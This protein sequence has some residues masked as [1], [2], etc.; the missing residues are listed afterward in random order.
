MI[1]KRRTKKCE[2]CDREISL[3]NVSKHERYHIKN[4]NK[5][6]IKESWNDGDGNY[7]CPYCEK[8]YKK[9]G[10]GNH[11]FRSHT[12]RGKNFF[13]NITGKIWN[14]GLTKETDERV[15]KNA[16]SIKQA[17][18]KNGHPSIGKTHS[19]ES[20]QHLSKIAKERG[21]GG[22]TYKKLYKYTM[23]CGKEIY[24]DSSYEIKVAEELDKNNIRWERSAPMKWIDASNQ[25]HNYHADFY[26]LDYNIYLDPKNDYLIKKDKD[27]I[28]RASTQNNV[29]IIVLSKRELEWNVILDKIKTT[30]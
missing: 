24:M 6:N 15:R 3:S 20:K 9:L 16:E 8:K 13:T 1:K 22:K 5:I 23:V 11:I 17:F 14:K 26:L 19:L 12:E 4:E 21:I 30:K 7:Q 2:I 28:H 10:I 25:K 27:K 29:T 18:I